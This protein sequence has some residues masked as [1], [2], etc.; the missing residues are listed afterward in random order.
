VHELSV[1]IL[2]GFG[3][4][5]ADPDAADPQL[6]L[7]WSDDGG[8]TWVGGVTASLGK[9]GERGA[10]ASFYQLGAVPRAGR[11]FQLS[12]SASVMR[13]ILNADARVQPIRA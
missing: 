10:T 13:G 12:S 9:A 3:V 11:T 8:R 6:L 7:N 5:G 1:D 4:N 2:P